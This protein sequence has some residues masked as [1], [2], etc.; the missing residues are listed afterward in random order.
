MEGAGPTDREGST[1]PT[2]GAQPGAEGP[3]YSQTRVIQVPLE[4]FQQNKIVAADEENPVAD[5]F[6]LLRTRI[7]QH[8]RPR[9]WNTLQIT[10]FDTGEGKSLVAA[11]LAVSIA[12]DTRQT[13]LLVDLDF[14]RP[15]IGRLFC[16]GDKTVGLESYFLDNVP[17]EDI[18]V[19]PGIEKLTLLPS[20]GG[21]FNAT[22]WMGSPRMEALIRELKQRYQDRYILIDS[23]GINVCPDPLVI[24]EYVD[25][26][27]IVARAGHTTVDSVTA[28]LELIP[29]EKVIGFVLNDDCE[30]ES[31]SYY[32]SRYGQKP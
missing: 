29:R 16:L 30:L 23:P 10:G 15:S 1:L 27:L 11:N 6:K 24:S 8:T 21:I 5:R 14:R 28:A 26:L 22:E 9:G 2:E 13:T 31:L 18:L 32:Y 4:K 3:A 7:F 17:L 12:K 20:T 25:A 19:S